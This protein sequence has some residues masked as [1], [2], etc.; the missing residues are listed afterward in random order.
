MSANELAKDAIYNAR[1]AL[2]KSMVGSHIQTAFQ[3]SSPK[4]SGPAD[5]STGPFSLPA[6]GATRI[7]ACGF[8]IARAN[9]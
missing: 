4:L 5:L 6:A 7:A 1:F 2:A 9:P 3:A 8:E